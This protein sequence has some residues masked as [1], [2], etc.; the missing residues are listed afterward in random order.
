MA[1]RKKLLM[2]GNGMAGVRT[3]EECLKLDATQYDITVFGAEPYGNYNRIMLSPVLANELAVED[4]ITHPPQW[5]ADNGIELLL[6]KRVVNIDR[7]RRCVMDESGVEYEYDRLLITTGS[8]PFILP[9]EG[10]E[11][12]G[13]VAYRDIDDV[14]QMLCAS[15]AYKKAVVIGGGL[16]GLEAANGLKKQGMA[17]TVVHLASHLLNRQLDP[18]AAT[19]LQ[20]YLKAQGIEFK[21]NAQTDKLTGQSRV[22]R[23]H[24]T[25]GTSLEADLVVMSA[26]IVP[27]IELAKNS[28][29]PCE[30]GILV[31]DAMQ[32]DDPHI[33]AVGECA[34]HN[35]IT[36]G[37]VAPLYEQATVCAHHLAGIG[38][39]QYNGTVLSTKLKVTGVNVFSAG[40]FM[41]GEGTQPLIYSDPE[42]AIYKKL[43]VKGDYLVGAV[44][45]GATQDGAWYFDLIQSQRNIAS[46]RNELIFGPSFCETEEAVRDVA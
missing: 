26:G 21:M 38:D 9:I 6:G 11:L 45:Y 31:N 36:Y 16:L 2:I 27:R 30:R 13:V 17:V 22:Q 39:A 44:M 25:D 41:G 28:G 18:H 20:T 35:G 32:T 14:N 7:N 12:D 1:T 5:Y 15:K 24:F 42:T 43:V 3:L 8:K 33:Y 4:I 34:Q 46:I 19:L 37:L 29:L 10:N 23:I 40:D